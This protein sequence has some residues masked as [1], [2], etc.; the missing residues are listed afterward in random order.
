MPRGYS[1]VITVLSSF[2]AKPE[3]N[4]TPH[5]IHEVNPSIKEATSPL[6]QTF[7]TSKWL[8]KPDDQSLTDIHFESVSVIGPI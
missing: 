1:S 2:A 5:F 3:M 4:R 8:R 7:L 6:S